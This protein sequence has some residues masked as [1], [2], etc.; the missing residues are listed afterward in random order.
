MREK[1]R[2]RCIR[3]GSLAWMFLALHSGDVW[4]Y[5]NFMATQGAR[6]TGMAW[7]VA[8][9]PQDAST[10]FFNPAGMSTLPGMQLYGGGTLYVASVHYDPGILNPGADPSSTNFGLFFPMHGFLTYNLGPVALGFGLTNPYGLGG[11]WPDDWAGRYIIT[12]SNNIQFTFNPAISV[13]LKK[14]FPKLPE[15]Y[16][17]AGFQ[18]TYAYLQLRQHL[19]FQPASVYVNGA[20][21]PLGTQLLNGF[22]GL[23]WDGDDAQVKLS[24]TGVGYGYNVG[25]LWKVSEA[26]SL[27]VS[28]TGATQINYSGTGFFST[29]GMNPMAATLF[30]ADDDNVT[31]QQ[32]L[33]SELLFGAAYSP[34]ETLTLEFDF[35]WGDWHNMKTFNILFSDPVNPDTV[36]PM[37]YGNSYAIALGA[38]WRHFREVPLRAGFMYSITPIPDETFSPVLP[39]ADQP[40]V[41]LGTGY[42]PA[43]WPILIPDTWKVFIDLSCAVWWGSRTKNN[44]IPP[45]ISKPLAPGSPVGIGIDMGSNT[46]N[47]TYEWVNFLTSVSFGMA[48]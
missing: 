2:Y 11:R 46:A 43:R 28:Y 44:G 22:M 31:I 9:N 45:D 25:L 33:P 5:G 21:F 30:V 23:V 34:L 48:F 13:D 15:I 3:I 41:T 42:H 17:G 18:F 19:T 35:W 8:A 47:G 24:G 12:K 4:A 39:D 1:D 38:E 32:A 6:A 27:G 7:C 26:F 16:L 40:F 29:P 37:S 36:M 14:I 10:V 20:L